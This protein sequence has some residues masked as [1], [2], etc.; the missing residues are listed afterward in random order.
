MLFTHTVMSTCPKAIAAATSDWQD[1]AADPEFEYF[2]NMFRTQVDCSTAKLLCPEDA[3]HP[4]AFATKVQSADFPTYR[5][6][7][8]MDDDERLKWI[9]AMDTE[10][11]DLTERKA[12]EF[13][14]R[15]EA[16]SKG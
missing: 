15:Q 9:E 14:P 7:L 1:T 8:G 11:S 6:I 2:D 5:E 16:I 10:L 4:F 12:F 3:F 13:V